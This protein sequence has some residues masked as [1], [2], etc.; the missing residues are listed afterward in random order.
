MG[1]ECGKTP[2][3][4]NE[5]FLASI[6][7]T[8]PLRKLSYKELYD[9]IINY[10]QEQELSRKITNEV[11]SQTQEDIQNVIQNNITEKE[12]SNLKHV[13]KTYFGKINDVSLKTIPKKD[14]ALIM[15]E[16]LKNEKKTIEHGYH[17]FI[18][19]DLYNWNEGLLPSEEVILLFMYS[20]FKDDGTNLESFYN[21]LYL[22]NPKSKYHH[23]SSIV[24]F[25]LTCS[26]MG[27]TTSIIRYAKKLDNCN[28]IEDT[29]SLP[30]LFTVDNIVKFFDSMVQ[31]WRIKKFSKIFEIQDYE[32]T[33]EDFT[34]I[35]QNHKY[36]FDFF[37]LRKEFIK[38]AIIFNTIKEIKVAK[39][40]E[41]QDKDDN[42]NKN[43]NK[44]NKD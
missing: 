12:D 23:F 8:L 26:L 40:L 4:Y 17:V 44:E 2:I 10:R 31:D 7:N 43:E 27:Y 25:Y 36:I 24:L 1:G 20:L 33:L 28:K 42:N 16:L 6:I 35:F 15:K 37:S 34:E 13:D 22:I 21:L 5:E 3:V 30:E 11:I 19:S 39:D 29:I 41:E 9:I 32:L 18:L 14:Y 38:R